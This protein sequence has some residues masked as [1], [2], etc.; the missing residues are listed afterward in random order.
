MSKTLFIGF[1]CCMI[2]F[3]FYGMYM[4]HKQHENDDQLQAA[5]EARGG[6][7]IHAKSPMHVCMAQPPKAN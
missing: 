2:L 7:F 5:C 1:I 4:S 6:I 3:C